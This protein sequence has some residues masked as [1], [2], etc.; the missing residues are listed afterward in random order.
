[1]VKI[2]FPKSV[3]KWFP[4]LFQSLNLGCAVS[5]LIHC[6]KKKKTLV[7]KLTHLKA[8]GDPIMLLE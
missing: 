8:P 6:K 3:Q 2:M 1:M 4:N 7:K 5:N